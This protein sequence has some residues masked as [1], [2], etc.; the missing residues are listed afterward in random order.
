MTDKEKIRELKNIVEV[1][2]DNIS[3]LPSG[4]DGCWLYE[5]GVCDKETLYEK[6]NEE[7]EGCA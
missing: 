4:C 6:M 7:S 1:L 3:D 2:C 5:D